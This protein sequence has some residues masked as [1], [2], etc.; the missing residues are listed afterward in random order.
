MYNDLKCVY[1][2]YIVKGCNNKKKIYMFEKH[3]MLN[4]SNICNRLIDYKVSMYNIFLIKYPKYRIIMSLNMYDKVINHYITLK[5]LIPNLTKYLDDRNIATRKGYGTDYGIKL[6]KKYIEKNKKYG[7]F[8]ILKL[9]ISKYFYNI[10]HDILKSMLKGRLDDF[11]YNIICKIMDSTNEL[12]INEK[13]IKLKNN[14]LKYNYRIKEIKEIPI[15]R[16]DKGLPIGNMTSQFL[17]IYYLYK[18]DHYIVHDLKIKY[19]IRYMDDYILIHYDKN[20][21]KK[22]LLDISEKLK[23]E[24]RLAVNA[25]K[26]KIYESNSGFNFLGYK[27][28]VINNKTI[29]KI[30][31]CTIFRIRKRIKYII[32]NYSNSNFCYYYNSFSNYYNSFKYSKS[33]KIKRTINKRPLR[34]FK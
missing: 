10:D 6:I 31:K 29:V 11:S 17:A 7:K 34:S 25:K 14:E 4:I 8:Y 2:D 16:Y 18:L 22:C 21:L 5:Y 20:Y 13:I 12:Y 33:F 28:K 9:D 23:K 19:M 15:Y 1:E 32:K 3:K 27:F 26:T 30:S 24:Y